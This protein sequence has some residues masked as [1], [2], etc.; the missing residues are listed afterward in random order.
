MLENTD[1]GVDFQQLLMFVFVIFVFGGEKSFL[2]RYPFT[3]KSKL[4]LILWVWWG[5]GRP[6][7]FLFK[8][9][10]QI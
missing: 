10:H 1:H 2:N 3:Q 5:G 7:L 6:W 8:L 4:R 9:A